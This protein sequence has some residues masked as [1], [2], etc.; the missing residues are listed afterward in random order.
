MRQILL[1]AILLFCFSSTCFPFPKK[2]PPYNLEILIGR[3]L[4]IE[5]INQPRE[6]GEFRNRNL[7]VEWTASDLDHGKIAVRHGNRPVTTVESKGHS[8]LLSE[9]YYTDIDRNGYPDVL[10]ALPSFGNGLEAHRSKVVVL[11]QTEPGH[12]RML[13]FETLF[14][15]PN[16]VVDL[17]GDGQFEVTV[18]DLVWVKGQDGKQ[19]SIWFY[20]PYR[21]QGFDL[22]MD[23]RFFPGFNCAVRFTRKPNNKAMKLTKE[24]KAGLVGKMPAVIR[25]KVST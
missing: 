3:T 6:S 10:I 12:F 17:D 18:T 5:P 14:F 24:Q 16:D 11:F 8:V 19:K 20:T 13:A 9:V 7:S 22:V 15:D 21:I 25:S 1:I 23:Q 4:N 2:Y